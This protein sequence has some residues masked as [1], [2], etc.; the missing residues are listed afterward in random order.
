MKRATFLY[1]GSRRSDETF[2]HKITKNDL[3]CAANV[4]VA[5]LWR[6]F[7]VEH[8]IGSSWTQKTF[9]RPFQELSNGIQNIE[10]R[11]KLKPVCRQTKRKSFIF[12]EKKNDDSIKFGGNKLSICRNERQLFVSAVS[13]SFL[14]C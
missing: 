7:T 13:I 4:R 2:D 1:F 5:L 8:L 9:D 10:I 6:D 11:W 3:G 14:A 12:S